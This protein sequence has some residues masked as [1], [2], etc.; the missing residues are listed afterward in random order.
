MKPKRS[1]TQKT[2]KTPNPPKTL[3]SDP[4]SPKSICLWVTD[5]QVCGHNSDS[6][7]D[8]LSHIETM[9]APHGLVCF[10]QDCPKKQHM[11]S[12]TRNFRNHLT[13]HTGEKSYE[14]KVCHIK[15]SRSGIAK[16]RK[17]VHPIDGVIDP[18]NKSSPTPE[19]KCSWEK[20]GEKCSYDC[21]DPADLIKHIDLTHID[22]TKICYWKGCRQLLKPIFVNSLERK[23]SVLQDEKAFLNHVRSHTGYQPYKCQHCP[24]KF[25]MEYKLVEHLR[26]EHPEPASKDEQPHFLCY[27]KDGRKCKFAGATAVELTNHIVSYHKLEVD[28]FACHWKKCSLQPGQIKSKKEFILHFRQEHNKEDK[29]YDC[30]ECGSSFPW[31]SRLDWHRIQVHTEATPEFRCYWMGS[32]SMCTQIC[33]N[34]TELA[35]HIEAEHTEDIEK[36]VCRWDGCWQE[37]QQKGKLITHL[38]RHTGEKTH[39]CSLCHE[40]FTRHGL[41][42]HYKSEHKDHKRKPGR[43]RAAQISNDNSEDD[44]N[45][46][47]PAKRHQKVLKSAQAL[48]APTSLSSTANYQ[49]TDGYMPN[50]QLTSSTAPQHHNYAASQYDYARYSGYEEEDQGWFTEEAGGVSTDYE[51]ELERL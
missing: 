46:E 32:F 39:E 3:C 9:H 21:Q 40:K 1:T 8:L 31:K 50:Q 6:P 49:Y 24:K 14:C 16:H 29:P 36:S 20:N 41:G 51:F 27:W 37:F 33:Q 28:N 2:K 18:K 42:N 30:P 26:S 25:A 12:E 38:L 4:T 44:E 34:P 43:K 45:H 19:T 23:K 35:E 13:D 11:Y 5:G 7:S 10:W 22:S 47:Q 15:L 48:T 17:K